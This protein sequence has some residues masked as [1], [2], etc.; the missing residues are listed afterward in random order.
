MDREQENLAV[1]AIELA[2]GSLHYSDI[3]IEKTFEISITNLYELYEITEKKEYLNNALLHIRA[4][5]RMGFRYD[6]YKKL[7]DNI[8][9]LIGF[10]KDLLYKE[11]ILRNKTVKLTRPQ[12]RGMIGKW[13]PSASNKKKIGE[14]VD[15]IIEKV[16]AQD[17]GIYT[18]SYKRG[19]IE[20]KYELVIFPEQCF[21]HD[22]RQ[23]KYYFFDLPEQ[24]L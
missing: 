16:K 10:D 24:N 21:F 7:F 6:N 8:L 2:Y 20:Y 14:V 4:Y 12:I 23:R 22:V 1:Q 19:N 11:S 17:E 5:V 18:Y 15:E 13:M 3:S 9:E